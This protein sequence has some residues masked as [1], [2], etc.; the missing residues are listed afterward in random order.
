VGQHLLNLDSG[1]PATA[2]QPWLRAVISGQEPAVVGERLH[3]VNRRG[4]TV[5]LR[6][7][8]TPLQGDGDQPA[9]ALILMEEVSGADS[10][11]EPAAT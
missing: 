7:N 1:L 8:V 9:G 11:P 3:A 4:R 5:H 10:P 2:L 6:V